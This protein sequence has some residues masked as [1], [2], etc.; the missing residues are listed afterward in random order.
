M[1]NRTGERQLFV[2][3]SQRCSVPCSPGEAGLL[4]E[5][6]VFLMCSELSGGCYLSC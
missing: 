2:E 1:T 4:A 5:G 6:S 3:L